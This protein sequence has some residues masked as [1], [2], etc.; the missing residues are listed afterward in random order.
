[1]RH[2][3]V[4]KLNTH[5]EQGAVPKVAPTEGTCDGTSVFGRSGM[6]DD[7]NASTIE[8]LFPRTVI[9]TRGEEARR[10]H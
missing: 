4:R 10:T 6:G 5:K 7:G 1:M 8:G 9:R 2:N 3:L